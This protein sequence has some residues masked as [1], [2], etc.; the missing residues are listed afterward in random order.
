M[1]KESALS[2][3]ERVRASGIDISIDPNNDSWVRYTPPLAVE[4]M[5]SASKLGDEICDLLM[6][7]DR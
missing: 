4:D 6:K 1:N 7:E 5:M 2:F 3:I